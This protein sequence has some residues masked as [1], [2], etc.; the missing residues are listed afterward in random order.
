[1]TAGELLER[2]A[3]AGRHRR[4]P[5]LGEDLVRPQVGRQVRL[6]EIGRAEPRAI[7]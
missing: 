2:V 5:H 6:E 7:A 3:G 4:Q 1:M